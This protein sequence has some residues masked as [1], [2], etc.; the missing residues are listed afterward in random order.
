MNRR[1]ALERVALLVGGVVSAPTL[2]AF[3]EGCTPG[4]QSGAA[5]FSGF[6]K[7]QLSLVAEIAETILPATDTPGAKDAKVAEF[8]ELMLKDCYYPKDQNSFASGLEEISKKGFAK[9]SADERVKLLTEAEDYAYQFRE[10]TSQKRKL[11][12]DSQ[13]PFEEPGVP[14]FSLMKEL[15]LLGYFTSEVGATSALDYVPVPGRYEGCTTLEP[16]QK[17]WAL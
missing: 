17:A 2:L 13:Q 12:N 16:N 3:L 9:A 6:T 15:T 8:I 10:E 11:A 14:F 1:D 7:D 5:A 4:N